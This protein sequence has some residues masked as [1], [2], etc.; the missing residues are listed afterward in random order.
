MWYR[1][2]VHLFKNRSINYIWRYAMA[3]L[4]RHVGNYAKLP[5]YI[6]NHA[7]GRSF[8]DIGCM[9]GVNGEYAFIAEES[10]ATEV[11]GVD[12]FGPTPEFEEKK[13]ARNSNVT[14]ILG[15]AT[16][17]DTIAQ[18]GVV[19]I[20]FCAGVLYHHPSPFDLLVALRRMCGEMLILRTSTIPE[21]RALPN[22]AVYWPMLSPTDRK[23][24]NLA[25]LGVTHQVGITNGFEP[26]QGFG[27]WFWGL[28]PSA[29]E[30]LLANAGFRV[31][32]RATEP[33]AR[34]VICTPV[35]PPFAHR[36][37]GEEEARHLAAT[38]SEEGLA[39]PA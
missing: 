16:H 12:V 21:N 5:D 38:I 31:D 26:E 34:T 9:W 6:R 19:D 22:M 33:F 1:I 37:P 3:Y 25:N 23:L 28:S 36:L 35:A 17:P 20:V 15:D 30:S 13:Q 24:W 14:F 29:L 8:V 10:G 2:K 18:V 32:F 4:G 39:S 11:K 27:N 7:A